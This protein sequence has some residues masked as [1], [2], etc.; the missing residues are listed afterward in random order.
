MGVITTTYLFILNWCGAERQGENVPVIFIDKFVLPAADDIALGISFNSQGSVVVKLMGGIGPY[1]A[2]SGHIGPYRA[3]SGHIRPYQ[4]ISGFSQ[5]YPAK[6][7]K[8]PVGY[9]PSS[10]KKIK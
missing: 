2:I 5:K 1:R 7:N 8:I 9:T 6:K 10:Q 3:I 4:A